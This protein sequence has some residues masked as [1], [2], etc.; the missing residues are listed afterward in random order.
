MIDGI[1]TNEPHYFELGDEQTS[2]VGVPGPTSS[3]WMRIA[4]LHVHANAV[5][6]VRAVKGGGAV[7]VV[8][9]SGTNQTQNTDAR[10]RLLLRHT[11]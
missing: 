8:M 1:S 9:T 4:E 3:P 10:N 6:R 7:N 2:V 5:R 11:T